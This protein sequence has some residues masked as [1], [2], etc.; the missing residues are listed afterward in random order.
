MNKIKYLITGFCFVVLTSFSSDNLP[1]QFTDLLNITKMTF[2]Q[3]DQYSET[4]VIENPQMNYEYAIINNAKEF[5]I[6]YAIRPLDERIKNHNEREKNKKPG[7]INIHPNKLHTATFQAVVFNVSGGKFPK[8]GEFEPESVKKEFNA[9]WGALTMVEV[10]KEFGT[11]Y[12]YCL[13]I[14]IHKDDVADAYFFYLS[15]TKED[16]TKNMQAPFHALR[17]K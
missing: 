8:I 10:G 4:P 16:I 2:D 5:E 14:T 1:K 15:N 7:D 6:R 17:F 11:D 12:K 9:D 13:L 3:P